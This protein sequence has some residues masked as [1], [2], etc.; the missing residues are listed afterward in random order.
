MMSHH[1]KGADAKAPAPAPAF[2]SGAASSSSAATPAP[3]W[4]S[5]RHHPYP[6]H[7]APECPNHTVEVEEHPELLPKIVHHHIENG[8]G[9]WDPLMIYDE[10][11]KT[12]ERI[13]DGRSDTNELSQLWAM[14]KPRQTTEKTI[15]E[16]GDGST[17]PLTLEKKKLALKG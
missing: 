5:P 17:R 8:G 1:T 15:I 13:S 2:S 14:R 4:L 7:S 10:N 3:H 6:S 11:M 12:Q 9:Q 16:I